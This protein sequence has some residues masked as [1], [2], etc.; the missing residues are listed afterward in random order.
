MPNRQDIEQL[1]TALYAARVEGSLER[2]CA[3][4]ASDAH[5]KIAGASDG[6]P[7]A[8]DAHGS[9]EIRP[10]LSMMVKTFKL[11]NQRI[12]SMVIEQERASVHWRA[13]IHS[14]I[15]GVMV[16]TELID[17]VSVRD[18]HIQSYIEFFVPS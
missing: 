15:T 7:I 1:L 12:L 16:P 2:L 17:M 6:K 8:I 18:K 11:S 13:D 3:L 5:F 14:R 9:G 10:W 4:F